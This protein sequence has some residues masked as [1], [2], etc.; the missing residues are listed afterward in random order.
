MLCHE[1]NVSLI[2]F[3]GSILSALASSFSLLFVYDFSLDS[4]QNTTIYF[5]GALILYTIVCLLSYIVNVDSDYQ[6]SVVKIK[7]IE[8]LVV[9]DKDK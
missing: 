3:I 8:Q 7:M 2:G 1:G 5:G 9:C 6:V 4:I